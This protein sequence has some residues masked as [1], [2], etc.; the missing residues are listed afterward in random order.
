MRH[1]EKFFKKFFSAH[2]HHPLNRLNADRNISLVV[3]FEG[4]NGYRKRSLAGLG[5]L[6]TEH[7]MA[8]PRTWGSKKAAQGLY[9]ISNTVRSMTESEQTLW[10]DL[11]S[12]GAPMDWNGKV[13]LSPKTAVWSLWI[14]WWRSV[15]SSS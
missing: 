11:K 13:I 6:L 8:E 2:R 14:C 9:S 1:L 12:L 5:V 4:A 10:I 7:A 3:D 15:G